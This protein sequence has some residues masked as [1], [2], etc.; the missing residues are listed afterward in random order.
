MNHPKTDY[1]SVKAYLEQWGEY[2]TMNPSHKKLIRDFL[3]EYSEFKVNEAFD[4]TIERCV[5]EVEVSNRKG[6]SINAIKG[7]TLRKV[8][9]TKK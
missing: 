5:R 2:T 8:Y 9:R 1:S 7:L 4:K 6:E 3:K